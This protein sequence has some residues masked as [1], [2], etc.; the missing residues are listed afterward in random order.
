ML[1]YY[2]NSVSNYISFADGYSINAIHYNN[3]FL[4]LAAGNDG[5]LLYRWDETLSINLLTN[6]D[7]GDDN[8][9]YDF[10]VDGNNIYTASE[11]G[12]S[13]YKIEVE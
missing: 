10:K 8:Y 13:I 3:G 2:D 7:S 9:V 5:V 11:N 6:I 1:Q 12:I 4:A